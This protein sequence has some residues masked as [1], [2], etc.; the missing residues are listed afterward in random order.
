M[1]SATW[2]NTII[3]YTYILENSTNEKKVWGMIH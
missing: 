3:T 1:K 2:L